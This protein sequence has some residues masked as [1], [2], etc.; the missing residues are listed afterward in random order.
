MGPQG[1][2]AVAV[3]VGDEI[4]PRSALNVLKPVHG[5]GVVVVP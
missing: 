3:A 5:D 4:I 1:D 2:A